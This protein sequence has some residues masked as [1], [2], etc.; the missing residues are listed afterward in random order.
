MRGRERKK[1]RK[2]ERGVLLSDT[3]NILI[4]RASVI[5]KQKMAMQH[6][7]NDADEGKDVGVIGI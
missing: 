6:W 5:G 4:Y 1:E 2:K 7:R 3:D